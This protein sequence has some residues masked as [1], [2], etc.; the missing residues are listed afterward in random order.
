MPVGW[1]NSGT[2]TTTDDFVIKPDGFQLVGGCNRSAT[3]DPQNMQYVTEAGKFPG[4]IC[5][6]GSVHSPLGPNAF[7]AN[8][9]DSMVHT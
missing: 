1:T 9:E 6:K 7:S 8:T 4:L 5:S 3:N 2:K